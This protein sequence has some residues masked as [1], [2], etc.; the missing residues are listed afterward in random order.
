MDYSIGDTAALSS[1]GPRRPQNV[2]SFALNEGPQ[3]APAH[4]DADGTFFA[5]ARGSNTDR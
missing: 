1:A 3:S 2:G 5:R 4:G